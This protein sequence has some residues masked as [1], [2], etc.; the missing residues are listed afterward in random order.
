L[1]TRTWATVASVG[2]PPSISRAGAA[3]CST[4]SSHLRQAYFGPHGDQHA[5]LRRHDVK[6]LAP[7]RANAVQLALAGL[8]IDIDD[9]FDPR[10]M[11]WQ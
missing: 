3:A 2:D 7:V 5:E 10:R 9:Q 4:P 11:G 1:E 8:V 6:P